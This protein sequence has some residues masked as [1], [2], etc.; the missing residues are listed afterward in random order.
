M[1]HGSARRFM[2]CCARATQRCASRRATICA[3]RRC[4]RRKRTP[5]IAC[6]AA[7]ATAEELAKFAERFTGLAED[8]EV[9]VYFK[10]EDEPSG[11]LN[12]VAFLEAC[13]KAAGKR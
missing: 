9:Y 1:S 4:R 2:R 11:A 3:R 5:A 8:R 13:A 10:H 7:A 12:A 6:G